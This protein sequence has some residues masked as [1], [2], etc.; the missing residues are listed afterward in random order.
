MP[1]MQYGFGNG[2]RRL[3]HL[4]RHGVLGPAYLATV[5]THWT[6]GPDY[7]AVP[8]RGR[9]ATELGGALLSQAIHAHDLLMRVLGPVARV[10]ARTATRVND[11]ETE[12]C[13]VASLLMADGALAALSV[14]LG[15]AEEISRLRFCFEALTAESSH[16]PYQPSAEPWTMIPRSEAH[17]T[18]I[19]AALED[20]VPEEEGFAR[21]FALLHAAIASGGPLPVTVEDS[22]RSIELA[23][24]L[25]HSAA[26]AT[27]V[28]LPLGRGHPAY[29]GWL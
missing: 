9:K 8:W 6:R 22:R 23:S 15:A 18:R 19:A 11:I 27:D 24:A 16:T 5:E 7:Y 26:N 29:R 20:F 21:Q 13:A 1:V 3:L 12:D 25:Y 4:Q 28:A 2:L 14:T 17:A 10:F